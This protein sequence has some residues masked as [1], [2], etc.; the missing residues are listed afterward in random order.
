MERTEAGNG[1]IEFFWLEDHYFRIRPPSAGVI[2]RQVHAALAFVM[3]QLWGRPPACRFAELLA[4]WIWAMR[5]R[6]GGPDNWQTGGL[7]HTPA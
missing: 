3:V 4:P 5:V 2:R 1:C 6:A 7:P